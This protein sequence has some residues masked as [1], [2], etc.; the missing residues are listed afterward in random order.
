MAQAPLEFDSVGFC[1]DSA[2][3]AVFEGLSARIG[4]GWTGVIGPNGSGK[5]TLLRLACGE[6][7]PQQGHIV[8]PDRVIYC[9]QRT[10]DP[11]A[12]LASFLR[13]TDSAACGLRG[14]LGLAADWLDRWDTLSHGERKRAQIAVALWRRPRVLAVDEP[15]NHID[16]PARRLLAEA[17]RRFRGVGLLV[18]HDRDLLDALCR[19]CLFVEPPGAVV[20]PGGYTKAVELAAA[21][22]ATARHAREQAKRRLT[23]LRKEAAERQRL[24]ARSHRMRSKRGIPIK[25]HDAR[26]RIDRARISGKDGQA[27]RLLRQMD[28]RVRQA[29]DAL[30][31]IHVTKQRQLGV[32]LRGE[33][34]R[35][36]ALLRLP[37]GAVALGTGRHMVFPELTI[38]PT[39]RIALTGPN[40]AGKS[41]LVR[42]ILHALD[43]P[44]ARRVY[45]A[46][47]ID[48]ATARATVTAARRL[49]K[50]KLGEVLSVV[51]CLGSEPQ[52]LLETDEPSPGELRKLMLAMGMANTPHLIVMDEP[53]N[54][55]DLPSIECL[56]AALSD[57]PSALLLVSHDLRFLRCL[58]RTRWEIQPDEADPTGARMC[59]LV[60]DAADEPPGGTGGPSAR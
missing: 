36:D 28:G 20:R 50:A 47:E 23:R 57:C 1:Y 34:S 55:L 38:G 15:T 25:D 58:T 54:H 4:A 59:L 24:A 29:G 3:A 14:R 10:D 5:T 9:P 19:Q 48:R 18:S 6:L 22:Q 12:E 26:S 37:A 46:Q 60:R 45:L 52:R 13:A 41:T 32:D 43:L 16:L 21:E 7:A 51:S 56:E 31:D 33:P 35:R 17:L 30:A 40:G 2:G 27:G 44:A 8:R 39:D 11:P 53:T 49:P 42:H